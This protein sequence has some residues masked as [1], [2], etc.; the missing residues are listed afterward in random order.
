M[1]KI[2]LVTTPNPFNH[3]SKTIKKLNYNSVAT[4]EGYLKESPI[5]DPKEHFLVV[6][7]GKIVPKD[8]Y[9]VTSLNKG[10]FISIV[11]RISMGGGGTGKSILSLVAGLAL[12]Y[13]S[14]GVGGIASGGLWGSAMATW[15]TGG[16]IAAAAT[17]FVGGMLIN[18]MTPR[19]KID[20][21]GSG[22]SD[23]EARSYTWGRLQPMQGQGNA[24]GITYGNVQ[25]P[26]QILAQYVSVEGDKQY[27]NV[28]LC[29]GEGPL[30]K[31]EN[32]KINDNP[33][34]NYQGVQ[35]EYRM[36]T[37]RKSQFH[38]LVIPMRISILVMI[39]IQSEFGELSF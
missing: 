2:T 35:V 7:N 3:S 30:D 33:I 16:M 12:A 39:W 21:G 38:F 36:G 19:P 4:L 15:T 11:P 23:A 34:E 37:T 25:A 14:F 10:S 28:L 13:V 8:Q 27:L 17:M 31:I 24:V 26:T 32:L 18:R 1:N 6:V 29:A 9:G 22:G 20:R 5:Y